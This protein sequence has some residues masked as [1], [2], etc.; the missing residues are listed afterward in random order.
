MSGID[1]GV[2]IDATKRFKDPALVVFVFGAKY[3]F[4]HLLTLEIVSLSKIN[5]LVIR[6][7]ILLFLNK[8]RN[9]V[10]DYEKSKISSKNINRRRN[11]PIIDRI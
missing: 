7:R 10:D 11:F 4:K 1:G 8:R 5:V 3:F 6:N 2:G 9:M